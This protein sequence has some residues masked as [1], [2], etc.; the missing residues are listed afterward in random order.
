MP[1]EQPALK[2]QVEIQSGQST[3]EWG[4]DMRSVAAATNSLS[5]IGAKV[6]QTASTAIAQKMGYNMGQNPKGDMLPPITDFDK[7]VSDSYNTQANASLSLQADKLFTDSQVEMAKANRLTP[8]LI[9]KTNGQVGNSLNKIL[10]QAPSAIK[11]SLQARFGSQLLQVNG[12][13][14][15]KMIGQQRS[16]QKDNLLAGITLNAKNAM[17][18]A[19]NGNQVEADKIVKANALM[20]KNGLATNLI[21]PQ[22]AIVANETAQKSAINGK[23]INEYDAAR[24]EGKAAEWTKNFAT[25]KPAGMTNAQHDDAI[26]AVIS[27]AGMIDSLSAQD[28]N[29]KAQQMT[30]Q[31][32]INPANI[33][34]TE[35]NTFKASV[36]P[37]KAAEVEFKYI[38]ALK[39]KQAAGIS[40][41]DLIKNISNSEA[42]SKSSEKTQNDAFFKSVDYVEAN[43]HKTNIPLK[44]P[45]PIS[46]A[47]AQVLVAAGAGG[48][49]KAFTRQLKDQLSSANPAF[50]ESAA[51]QIHKL[52]AMGAGHALVG[53]SE[54]DKALY[55]QYETLR[56]SM[57]PTT[58]ARTATDNI[59]NQDPAVEQAVKQQ[60]SNYLSK[61]TAGGTT[62]TNFALTSVGMNKASFINSSMAMVYGTDILSKFNSSFQTAKGDADLAMKLTKQYVN[63]NYGD[64][65]I[66]GGSHKTLHPIEKVLGFQSH[67]AVPFIQQDVIN[68]MNEKMAP[69][70][71]EYAD[72]KSNEYWETVPLTGA[73]HGLFRTTYDP[74]Q[75]KRHLRTATGEQ[76]DTYNVV[77]QGNDFDNWDIAIQGDSGMRNLFLKAPQLGL[78]SYSPN[79]KAIKESYNKVH[80]LK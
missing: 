38:Q 21:D 74:V 80:S 44:S 25:A 7:T 65:L 62:L 14:Q 17:E 45:T 33:T 19:R 39:T 48:E 2:R 46:H 16:D 30:N 57:D 5:S 23:A 10:D 15:L 66:N 8:D 36:S 71:Q 77:L 26:S 79:A 4:A 60:L 22:T 47:D 40:T 73:K 78:I 41:D 43:S 13:Y 61:Q 63:D 35:W 51:Q 69:L 70:K 75:V 37:L 50:I 20:V 12:N 67:D 55:M 49:V 28:E 34:G 52:Q 31:I 53:L 76:V 1:Q 32:A 72:K 54:Q 59:L 64:T 24:A 11:G 6:S 56:S 29:L 42:W 27:H 68:Q 3:P 18:L 9:A 58:A